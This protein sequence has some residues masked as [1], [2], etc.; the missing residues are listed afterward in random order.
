MTA[1]PHMLVE[2]DGP[3]VVLASS[4]GTDL[5]MW[6]AQAA[7]LSRT[8]TVVRY[9]ERGHGAT[10]WTG[11]ALSIDDLARDL[12]DVLDALAHLGADRASICGVSLGGMT[13]MAAARLA[14]ERID[15]LVLCCTAA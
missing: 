3:V 4:L 9:D 5:H 11:D 2:G 12:L 10:P 8:M 1:R 15:R 14:S 7:V 6:D 13:A